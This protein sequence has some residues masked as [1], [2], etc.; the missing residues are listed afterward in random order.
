MPFVPAPHIARVQM[1]FRQDGQFCENVYHI[2]AGGVPF[3]ASDLLA[4]TAAFKTWWEASVRPNV[5][6]NVTLERVLATG[7]DSATAPGIED[8]FGLPMAGSNGSGAPLPNNVTVAIKWLT[9]FR[10]RWYRGRTYHIGLSSTS[11]VDSHITDAERGVLLSA[12]AAL[13]TQLAA[14]TPALTLGV[15]STI[16]G[17]APR[18]V[19]LFTPIQTLSIDPVIDS[20]RRRLPGRGA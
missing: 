20:Q 8:A 9:A 4:A 18:A 17:K 3:S 14:A 7:L 13:P 15:L 5:V 16:M 2:I 10:G 19:G 11:V 1:V 6:L 12:Y